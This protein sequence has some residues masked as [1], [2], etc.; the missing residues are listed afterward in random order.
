MPIGNLNN[1]F[2]A[3]VYLDR[4][5]QFVKHELKCRWYLRY[6]DDFVLLARQPEQL[7]QWRVRIA[8]FLQDEL[9]LELN[10]RRQRLAPIG[11]GVDFLGYIV[12]PDYLL[13]RKRVVGNLRERLNGFAREL[14]QAGTFATRYRHEPASVD[15]LQA[16]LASY[17]GHLRFARCRRLCARLAAELRWLD[18]YFLALPEHAAPVRRHRRRRDFRRVGAQYAHYFREFP[19]HIVLMQVGAFIEFYAADPK[20]SPGAGLGLSALRP[21]RRGARQGFPTAQLGRRMRGLLSAGRQVVLVA[22]TGCD[23]L[24]LRGRAPLFRYVPAW[25]RPKA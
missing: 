2:F 19:D 13:V 18:E 6:C 8:D 21:T 4:L 12:R 25:E 1:Q 24:R 22:Q 10:A 23:A 14:V 5:D 15:R 20:R 7:E 17:L 11:N 3:N 16:S 9:A